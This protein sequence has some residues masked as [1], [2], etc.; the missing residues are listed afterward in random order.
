MEEKRAAANSEQ[1]EVDVDGSPKDGS[2]TKTAEDEEQA[3]MAAL[4]LEETIPA[5][6]ELAWA[7]NIRD[8]SRTLKNSCK[9]LFTDAEV[10]M[11]TRIKRAEAI[12]I[13]GDE[14]YTIGKAR[15]GDEDSVT[16]TADIKARAEVAVM[17]T[18]AKAQGQ[19]VSDDDT[20]QMI[21]QAKNM[22]AEQATAEKEDGDLDM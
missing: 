22:R 11:A 20:E 8:I 1:I 3:K 21:K 13:I 17:A 16:N 6:L 7:V 12:R 10:P 15:G 2:E 4:K 9:K 5:I 14:F 19:E 18:M